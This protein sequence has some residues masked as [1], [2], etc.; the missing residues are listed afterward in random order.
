MFNYDFLQAKLHGIHSKSIVGD[1]F[2]RLKKIKTI[3]QLRKEIFPEDSTA[4]SER[5]LY[6]YLERNFKLRIFKQINYISSFY[7]DMNLFINSMILRYELD[8]VKLVVSAYYGKS[9]NVEELFEVKLKKTLD[10]ELIYKSDLSDIK[11]I[12]NIFGKTVFSFIL[13]MLEENQDIFNIEN[14]LDKFYYSNLLQS[15]DQLGRYEQEN[16]RKVII[17][18]MNWQN[19]TWAFRTRL[20]FKKS[21]DNIKESFLNFP[22]LI[23]SDILEK[24]FDLKFVPN[25]AKELFKGYP[26]RYQ[27]IILESFNE[28]G[29]FDLPLLED[30][31]NKDL[32]RLYTKYF[33]NENFNILPIISFIYIKKNEYA[34][35][36]KLIESV[37]YNLELEIA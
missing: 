7:D 15:L 16:L 36:V 11:N 34:N 18:E 35:V 29:D 30:N 33:F 25:E 1:N 9:K 32:M 28:D 2:N 4:I 10:Y 21:F 13:P 8:N 3:E 12:R 6:S 26:S 37:R 17:F 19:I 22:G 27:E 31:V 14:A 5:H 23:K 20:F 24:I